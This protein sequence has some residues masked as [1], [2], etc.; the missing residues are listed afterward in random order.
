MLPSKALPCHTHA[1]SYQYC[2][3]NENLAPPLGGKEIN[4][5]TTGFDWHHAP[6]LYKPKC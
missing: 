3:V 1:H 5:I 6:L 4:S 2:W